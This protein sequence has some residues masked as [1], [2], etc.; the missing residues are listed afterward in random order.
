MY[1]SSFRLLNA[2]NGPYTHSCTT[3]LII[4]VGIIISSITSSICTFFICMRDE[5]YV[6]RWM[7]VLRKNNQVKPSRVKELAYLGNYT[8]RVLNRKTSLSRI[9]TLYTEVPLYIYYH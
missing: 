8:K 7:P 5:G 2:V 6:I 3:R 4:Y 9:I 1:L